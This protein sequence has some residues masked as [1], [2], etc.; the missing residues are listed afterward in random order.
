MNPNSIEKSGTDTE[1]QIE[2][3]VVLPVLNEKDVIKD[4]HQE[5]TKTL[6]SLH[7]HYEII[8]V[9]DGS[10]DGSETILSELAQEDTSVVLI[11]LTRNFGHQEAF[12]AGIDHALGKAIIL[13][14]SDLQDHPNEIPKFIAAWKQGYQ[15]VYAIRRSRKAGPLM[16]LAYLCYYRVLGKLSDI[17][18]PVDAGDFCLMDRRVV[19]LLKSCPERTRFIRGLRSW[20]GLHQIGIEIDRNERAAGKPKYSFG[21][22]ILLALNGIISFSNVPLRLISY[23]GILCSLSSILLAIFYI[24]KKFTVGLNPPGFATIV[25]LVSFFAGLQLVCLGVIGEYL[26]RI[27]SEVKGRPT[28]L[29]K[30]IIRKKISK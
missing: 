8:Y 13:M 26:A 27:Y 15:V 16:K 30:E 20:V 1:Q 24:V 14:D 11:N 2:I 4:L 18:I 17:N 9:N 10:S 7:L 23:L 12:S 5:L 25:V 22:L 28:Y 21:K 6:Q 3:S 29:V 19:D